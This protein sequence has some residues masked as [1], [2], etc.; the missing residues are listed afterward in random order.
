M[1]PNP[2]T[3]RTPVAMVS[4]NVMT[5]ER[6]AGCVNVLRN[7]I[8]W[9]HKNSRP[10]TDMVRYWALTTADFQ[11]I[12]AHLDAVRRERDEAYSTIDKINAA[13]DDV[14]G[15]LITLTRERVAEGHEAELT[16]DV[17][18]IAAAMY[19]RTWPERT[20]SAASWVAR[21]VYLDKARTAIAAITAGVSST[22]LDE[23]R[24][25]RRSAR[26]ATG[27]G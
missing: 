4:L 22:E 7:A 5:E 16:P 3:P 21:P 11:V 10:T 27:G 24:A 23:V 15:S 25:D 12:L 6:V 17:E 9:A 26:P 13:Y 19:E 20:W 14:A 8:Q 2:T 18:R 1:S